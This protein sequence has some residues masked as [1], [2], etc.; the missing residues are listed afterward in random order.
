[1]LNIQYLQNIRSVCK[2]YAI[3]KEFFKYSYNKVTSYKYVVQNFCT[4]IFI[5]FIKFLLCPKCIEVYTHGRVLIYVNLIFHV[6]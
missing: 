3:I 1:M 4:N 6:Y 2:S 5:K